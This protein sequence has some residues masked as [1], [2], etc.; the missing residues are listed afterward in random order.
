[1]R[2]SLAKG[3]DGASYTWSRRLTDVVMQG[4]DDFELVERVKLCRPDLRIL[5]VAGYYKHMP[6]DRV[7]VG[8]GKLLHKPWRP[9]ELKREV[10]AGAGPLDQVRALR[11]SGTNPTF[12]RV[13]AAGPVS[14]AG[15]VSRGGSS[16]ASDNTRRSSLIPY[17]F[18]RNSFPGTGL[19]CP[20][21]LE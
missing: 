7:A 18:G 9:D 11:S 6:A 17:G 2:T 3:I 15:H 10:W 14:F 4:I 20:P 12:L 1:M 5:Y 21:P 8:Y 16:K 13:W 19:C